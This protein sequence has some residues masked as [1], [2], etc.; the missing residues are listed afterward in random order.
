MCKIPLK[1][2]GHSYI[3]ECLLDQG[4]T[5]QGEVFAQQYDCLLLGNILLLS[6]TAA[7]T[8]PIILKLGA[9]FFVDKHG[10]VMTNSKL[11]I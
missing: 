3:F 8:F 1:V 10:R 6:F 4:P 11:M 7:K 5:S 2:I 9:T